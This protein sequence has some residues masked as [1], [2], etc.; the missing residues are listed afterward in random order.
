MLGL[1]LRSRH[2][3]SNFS[4][5]ELNK[6]ILAPVLSSGDGRE[7]DS[8][9][10]SLHLRG[11]PVFQAKKEAKSTSSLANAEV[12]RGIGRLAEKKHCAHNRF[13]HH[14][15]ELATKQHKT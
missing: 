8:F 4:E 11:L 1:T 10:T 3:V 15:T 7:S 5:P 2:T 13:I 6:P 9:L 12:Q 14:T